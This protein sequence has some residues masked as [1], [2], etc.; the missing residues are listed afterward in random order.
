V[1]GR[2][3]CFS[4]CG[5]LELT[6]STTTFVKSSTPKNWS[7]ILRDCLLLLQYPGAFG[8]KQ[9]VCLLEQVG[10]RRHGQLENDSVL[11]FSLSTIANIRRRLAHKAD[12]WKELEGRS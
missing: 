2:S 1:L 5:S 11:R 12:L 10:I 8:G 3:A 7:P 6:T 4:S 9:R